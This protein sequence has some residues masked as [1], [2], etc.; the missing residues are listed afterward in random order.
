MPGLP[1]LRQAVAAHYRAHQNVA[2]DWE[3]EVM[4]T[5]GATEAIAGALM[6]EL[7]HRRVRSAE[8]I[9]QVLDLPVLARFNGRSAWAQPGL[10]RLPARPEPLALGHGGSA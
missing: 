10:P 1:E 6:L 7:S 3:R 2:L 5:S 8:D 4:I 9:V